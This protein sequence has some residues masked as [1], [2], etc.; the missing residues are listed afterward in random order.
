MEK[1]HNGVSLFEYLDSNIA[2]IMLETVYIGDKKDKAIA[3]R[4]FKFTLTFHRG[5]LG[6]CLFIML[7]LYFDKS[8][9]PRVPASVCP[10]L[11]KVKNMSLKLKEQLTIFSEEHKDI[12]KQL[13]DMGYECT[14][15]N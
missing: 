8:E 2:Q 12:D 7:G 1:L 3:E 9:P 4:K 13:H 5:L 15:I 11:T 6:G 14:N 10:D